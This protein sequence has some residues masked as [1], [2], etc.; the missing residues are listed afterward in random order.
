MQVAAAL[1]EHPLATHALGECVGHLLDMGGDAPDVL[2]VMATGQHV[3]ALDDIVAAARQLLAPTV[4]CGATAASVLAGAR[5]V[6][7]HPALSM[8][9]IWGAPGAARPVR[10]ERDDAAQ[11]RGAAGTLV[12][13]ADP[14]TCDPE[15]LLSAVGAVAP[16]LVVVGGMASAARHRGGNR[17]V[18]D[19]AQ[20]V[21]GAV[22]VLLDE[23]VPTQVVVS[24]GCR[25]VGDPMTVTA[26]ERT[27]VRELAGRPAL[28]RLTETVE[29]LGPED[30]VLAATGLQLGRVVQEQR[31]E[32]GPGDFLVR[33]VL[34]A[35]HGIGAVAVADEVPPG[36]TVQFHVRDATTAHEDLVGS[37]SG[38][39][40]RGALVFTCTGRGARLFGIPDHD[41]T[42]VADTLDLTSVAGMFCAGELGPVGGANFVHTLSASVLLVG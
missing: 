25:A 32:F 24:Q 7:E 14:F 13:F 20:F 28:E 31:D 30:R 38:L 37:L 12:L 1:S 42:T 8:F 27:V 18:L 35:D 26:A 3:G 6:E 11:L 15:E 9:A 39:R 16:D 34:G 41:A 21:D 5:E 17:L 36:T 40:A 10:L 19:G 2:V 29:R 23:S 22:G 4:M 33:G